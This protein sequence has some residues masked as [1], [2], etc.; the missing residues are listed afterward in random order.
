MIRVGVLR[1]GTG[2]HYEASLASGAELLR[3]LPRTHFVPVD[4][5]VDPNGVWHIGGRPVAPVDLREKIDV[6]WNMLHDAEDFASYTKI[7]EDLNT[8]GLPR[9]GIQP[10]ALKATL[11]KR[12]AKDALAAL[13]L[14][15]P[16]GVYIESWGEGTR[17]ETVAGVV[18]QL[19]RDFSPPWIVSPITRTTA[20]GP[21]RAKTRNELMDILLDTFDL[22]LPV[23]IEEEVLG[24]TASIITVPGFR[25][26][27]LYTF[28]PSGHTRGHDKDVS[29]ALG[30]AARAAH[31]GLSL[32]NYS[33]IEAVVDRKGRVHITHIDT[34]PSLAPDSDLH[35][36]LAAVGATFGELAK[37][38]IASAR[39]FD[40]HYK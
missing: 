32:G 25:G 34:V 37:H 20:F 24:R 21:M 23:L 17:E 8:L 12:H 9:I 7:A 13:G 40:T 33:R 14:R 35:A 22:L 31:T 18:G 29:R 28:M 19:A 38:L 15:T 5:Y 36:A 11:N 30:E 39:P 27:K 1:G 4:M 16:R 6:V 2:A 26:Q 3:A 10:A